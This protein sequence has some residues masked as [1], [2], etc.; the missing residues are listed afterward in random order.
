MCY[1]VVLGNWGGLC[2]RHF[3]GWA[4]GGFGW[5]KLEAMTGEQNG[6]DGRMKSVWANVTC[7]CRLDY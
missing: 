7:A 4:M 3:G 6:A 1:Y 2:G 5:R